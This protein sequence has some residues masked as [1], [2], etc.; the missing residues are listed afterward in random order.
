MSKKYEKVCTDLNY[1]EY[2]LI[3]ASTLTWLVLFSILASLVN[4]S[5]GIT[6]I[7]R[8]ALYGFKLYWMLTYFGFY[9][10]LISF[11]LYSCFFS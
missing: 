5:I 10:Y 6:A 9:A 11:I 3:L 4:I 8:K 2:S 1:T 7:V